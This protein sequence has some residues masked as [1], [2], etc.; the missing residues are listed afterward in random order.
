MK[1]RLAVSLWGLLFLGVS[2]A[3]AGSATFS[4]G[5][6]GNNTTLNTSQ[7]YTSH[8]ATITAY[9]YECS[10]PSASSTSTLSNCVA[11]DL[12]AKNGGAGEM[13]LGLVGEGGGENEIGYDAGN[14]DYVMGLDVSSLFHLGVTSMTLSFES[15][16]PGEAFAVL[17][18]ASDPFANSS[19]ALT[20][21][22]AWCGYQTAGCS[23]NGDTAS[24]GIDLNANDQ[25][26]VL[27]SPCGAGGSNGNVNG[28]CGSN[29]L[30]D[31]LT[32]PTPEP[33]TLL[34]LATGLLV[35]GLAVRRPYLTKVYRT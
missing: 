18:Y 15:V 12:F 30:L 10:A 3:F 29:V 31:S 28:P 22:K 35:L 32:A 25:F 16:Q 2:P 24:A 34:L 11:A 8:G 1:S 6:S 27:M 14:A 9:G 33:G 5:F 4:F 7:T 23:Y 21:T 20:N 26:L 17:G 13:G 19:I